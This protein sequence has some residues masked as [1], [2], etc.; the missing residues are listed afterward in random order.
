M[1]ALIVGLMLFLSTH[2]ARIFADANRSQYI[3]HYGLM[4]WK[5]AYSLVSVVGLGL[6]VWGYGQA[7]LD[8]LYLWFA[9]VWTRH[10]A[11]LLMLPAMVLLVAAYVPGTWMK[12]RLGHP[13]YAGVK[14]WALAH[15]L[16]NGTLAD[17]L[18]FGSFLAWAIAG[19]VSARRRDRAA[20]RAPPR[21]AWSRDAIAAVAG[22]ALWFAFARYLHV[23]L[24]GVAP[25][26]V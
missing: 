3:A 26:G 11:V 12:A 1:T 15:L 24:F 4:K 5:L 20:G 14:L 2:S 13:M 9:P 19:F 7:R 21:A 10:L 6:I 16:S 8:P 23:P 18:L 25:L 22:G 17:V